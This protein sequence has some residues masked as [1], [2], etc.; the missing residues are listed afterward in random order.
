MI[1]INANNYQEISILVNMFLRI[2]MSLN[3]GF[4]CDNAKAALEKAKDFIIL[5]L[6][7]QKKFVN[8]NP[9]TFLEDKG[10]G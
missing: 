5:S 6:E 7:H 4:L 1:N 8:Y 2:N 9:D 3:G 10:N